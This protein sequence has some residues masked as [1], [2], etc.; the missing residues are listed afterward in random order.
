MVSSTYR[1]FRFRFLTTLATMLSKVSYL[2][3]FVY[4]NKLTYGARNAGTILTIS[5]IID[6]SLVYAKPLVINSGSLAAGSSTSVGIELLRELTGIF[7][8]DDQC[9]DHDHCPLCHVG[10]CNFVVI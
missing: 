5:P 9:V 6:I 8:Q 10:Q 4:L 7:P 1:W 2:K 3:S